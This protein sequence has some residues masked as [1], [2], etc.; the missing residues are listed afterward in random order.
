MKAAVL[1]AVER[2]GVGLADAIV[3]ATETPARFLR[4][5]GERGRIAP[6]LRA[7][8]VVADAKL[9]DMEVWIGGERA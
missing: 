7:D 6:G 2:M 5:E 3:M 1:N 8:L 4:I 9:G